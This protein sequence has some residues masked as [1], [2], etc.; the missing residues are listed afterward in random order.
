MRRPVQTTATLGFFLTPAAVLATRAPLGDARQWGRRIPFLFSAVL[1]AMSLYIRMR[2]RES[3]LFA[4][5]K[6]QGKS[7]SAPLK[8]SFGNKRNWN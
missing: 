2:L 6:D 3:P 4:K 1:L 5:L 8:D 7:S